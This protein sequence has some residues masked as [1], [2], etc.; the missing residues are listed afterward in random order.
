MTGRGSSP[1]QSSVQT[2]SKRST[3]ALTN[4]IKKRIKTFIIAHLINRKRHNSPTNY[5]DWDVLRPYLKAGFDV[6]LATYKNGKSQD[7]SESEIADD[8]AGLEAKNTAERKWHELCLSIIS[9]GVSWR[10]VVNVV[11]VAVGKR[12]VSNPIEDLLSEGNIRSHIVKHLDYDEFKTLMNAPNN[13]VGQLDNDAKIEFIMQV[14]DP[15]SRLFRRMIRWIQ[16]EEFTYVK[17]LLKYMTANIVDKKG[18]VTGHVSINVNT[19]RDTTILMEAIIMLYHQLKNRK[20]TSALDFIKYLLSRD[21]IDLQVSKKWTGGTIHSPISAAL[22]YNTYNL[23]NSEMWDVV[24]LILNKKPLRELYNKYIKDFPNCYGILMKNGTVHSIY[25]NVWI[26]CNQSAAHVEW[27]IANG[28]MDAY[29]TADGYGNIR[30]SIEALAETNRND[31]IAKQTEL[32]A[33]DA[34]LKKTLEDMEKLKDEIASLQSLVSQQ[35]D[36]V[37][38]ATDEYNRVVNIQ[39]RMD[40]TFY[41]YNILGGNNKLRLRQKK[42]K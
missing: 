13:G 20:P 17:W 22:V 38:K 26:V 21:D 28:G 34:A 27:L 8:V 36:D 42:N 10:S 23:G 30:H 33:N 35:K 29:A 24:K 37:K 41:R 32:T 9:S 39:Q 5:D 40:D 3:T 4:D 6:V 18:N 12:G 19:Q 14:N 16:Q 7:K 31:M 25:D 15:Q 2:T 11:R 1:I